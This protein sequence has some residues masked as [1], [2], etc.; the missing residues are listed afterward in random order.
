MNYKE[1][2]IMRI[3]AMS[4]S[5]RWTEAKKE[6]Q[7]VKIAL[8]P[9]SQCLCGKFPITEV[10]TMGN[11]ETWEKA[12][13]GNCCVKK[14]FEDKSWSKAFNALANGKVNA[15]LIEHAH[16]K[17]L[18]NDWEKEFLL[19]TW[20]KT[21]LSVKQR[22]KFKELNERIMEALGGTKRESS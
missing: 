12:E 8:I 16:Y 11:K 15:Q 17:K 10:I 18:I 14:F 21:K 5:D 6:W 20:R 7:I 3:M 1:D 4:K 13:I 9:N 19:N 22:D 2:F